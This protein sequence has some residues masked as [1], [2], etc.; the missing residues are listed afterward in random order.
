MPLNKTT[1][2]PCYAIE[3][4]YLTVILQNIVNDKTL[5]ISGKALD[6]KKSNTEEK[7]LP[8]T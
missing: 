4:Y 3:E 8:F 5:Q 7:V 1:N 6:D 2:Q